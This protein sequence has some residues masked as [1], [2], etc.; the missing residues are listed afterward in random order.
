MNLRTKI[1]RQRRP[2]HEKIAHVSRRLFKLGRRDS[3]DVTIPRGFCGAQAD[4][5][6]RMQYGEQLRINREI[7]LLTR[8][9]QLLVAK[10]AGALDSDPL[11]GETRCSPERSYLRLVANN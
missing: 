9:L 6:W 11:R 1:G 8:R 5:W 10:Q 3:G 4:L 2:V 7:A